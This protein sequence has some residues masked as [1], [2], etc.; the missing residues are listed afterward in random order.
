MIKDL[1]TSKPSQ[2][3]SKLKKLCSYDQLKYEPIVVQ[4][5]KHLSDKDQAEVIF[6]FIFITIYEQPYHDFPTQTNT[7]FIKLGRAPMQMK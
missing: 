5:I 6:I 7:I 1:K 4:S 3:H 2:W